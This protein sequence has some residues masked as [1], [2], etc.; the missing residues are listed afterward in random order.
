MNSN[1]CN[2]PLG[3]DTLLAYWLGELEPA[4]EARTEEHYLGCALCSQRLD[5]LTALA[6]EVRALI[7]TR[8]VNL[9]INDAFVRRLAEQGLR[10]REYRV[11]L[12]GSVNCTVVPEDDMV[13]A[14]LEAPLASVQRLDLVTLG[15]DGAALMR[16]DDIPFVAASDGV[17]VSPGIGMLRS[18]PQ[19]VLRLRLLAVDDQGERP[20]GDYTFNHTPY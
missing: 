2:S 18:L 9:V 7:T 16:Q 8:G 5:E 6:A 4:A 11:P 17:V 20:L 3:W 12:N 13:V 10:V 14:Y 1:A 19:T 15:S